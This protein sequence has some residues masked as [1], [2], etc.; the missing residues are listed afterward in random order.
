MWCI[1]VSV[2]VLC[3]WQEKLEGHVTQGLDMLMEAAKKEPRR[4]CRSPKQNILSA[5]STRKHQGCDP[6]KPRAPPPEA[7]VLCVCLF[8]C[9]FAC[10]CVCVSLCV[11]VCFFVC[12]V[13]CL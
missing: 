11:C 4:L 2:H 8:V 13:V 10:L 5:V 7:G 1:F 9:L 6:S 12:L 3:A